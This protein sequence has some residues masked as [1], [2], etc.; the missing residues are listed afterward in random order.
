MSNGGYLSNLNR[1]DD[2]TAA[3]IVSVL[4]RDAIRS[5]EVHIGWQPYGSG[6]L[7]WP[8]PT[9]AAVW[10]GSKLHSTNHG[11][12]TDFVPHDVALIP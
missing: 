11:S 3:A 12:S 7:I 2:R 6:Y 4:N 8:K 1:W 10:K 9:I 5:G